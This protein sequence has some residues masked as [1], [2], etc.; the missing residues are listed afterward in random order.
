MKKNINE[1]KKNLRNEVKATI[2]DKD[3]FDYLISLKKGENND[4]VDYTPS[5]IYL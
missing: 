5:F 3:Y 2:G 4:T 1:T